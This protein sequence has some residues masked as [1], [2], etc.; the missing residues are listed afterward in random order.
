MRPN[1]A[2]ALTPQRRALSRA[3]VGLNCIVWCIVPMFGESVKVGGGNYFSLPMG[4]KIG[5]P[6]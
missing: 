2:P 6:S 1:G 4:L 5:I 3:A